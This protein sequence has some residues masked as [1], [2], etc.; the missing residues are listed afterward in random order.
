MCRN[1]SIPALRMEYVATLK[2]PH[3]V[4]VDEV[5]Q[6]NGKLVEVTVTD[7]RRRCRWPDARLALQRGLT[8]LALDRW[9][10]WLLRG[11][12]RYQTDCRHPRRNKS[13]GLS[14]TA[15]HTAF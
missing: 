15:F 12:K 3:P 10:R 8:N 5:A 9:D 2:P 14:R 11:C 1:H 4:V 13:S 7:D 6:A